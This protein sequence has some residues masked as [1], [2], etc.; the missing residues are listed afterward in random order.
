M[1]DQADFSII[2]ALQS[3]GPLNEYAAQHFPSPIPNERQQKDSIVCEFKGV[4]AV[5]IDR[6]DDVVDDVLDYV[7]EQYLNSK[8][9]VINNEG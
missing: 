5:G 1:G 3:P 9:K 8:E 6:R 2:L 4:L 7:V